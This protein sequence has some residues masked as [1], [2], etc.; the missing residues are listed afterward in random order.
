M[1]R[2]A[3]AGFAGNPPS[4]LVFSGFRRGLSAPLPRNATRFVGGVA[5]IFRNALPASLEI[6]AAAPISAHMRI[7]SGRIN[8]GVPKM[9]SARSVVLAAPVRTAIGTFGGSLKDVP[10]TDLGAAAIRASV[11]RAGLEP[12]E[13]GTVV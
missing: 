8:S 9:N 7:T 5:R 4:S 1:S 2:N 13:I 12:D 10:S 3:P 6:G 11:Q